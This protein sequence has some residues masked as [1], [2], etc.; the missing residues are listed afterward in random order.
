MQGDTMKTGAALA[1]GVVGACVLTLVHEA[2]R[3]SVPRSPRVNVI[4]ERAVARV[5]RALGRPAPRGKRR[6]LTAL[7]GEVAS[8]SLYYSLVALGGAGRSVPLGALLGAVGGVGA[9]FLPGPLGLGR[10]PVRRS[11]ATQAM[12][13]AW[14]TLGGIAAG[15]TYRSLARDPR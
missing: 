12:T 13:L 4:G 3:R 14:Y 6:Y 1:S 15:T 5:A 9:V 2:A 7:G 10:R 11:A 8:N